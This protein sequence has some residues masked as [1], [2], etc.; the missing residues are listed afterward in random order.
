MGTGHAEP[1]GPQGELGL[2]TLKEMRTSEGRAVNREET[3]PDLSY[4][5]RP[6]PQGFVR[7]DGLWGTRV[8]A[9]WRDCTGPG[10]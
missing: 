7:E 2:S 3:R 8:R 9:G 4:H 5:R 10:G 6:P 1:C